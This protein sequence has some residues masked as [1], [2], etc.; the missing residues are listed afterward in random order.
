MESVA[1]RAEWALFT[2]AILLLRQCTIEAR[3][4]KRSESDASTEISE[5]TFTA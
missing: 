3:K 1:G 2:P 5:S 4:F